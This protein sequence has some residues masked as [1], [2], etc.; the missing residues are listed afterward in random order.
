MTGAPGTSR[1]APA[2]SWRGAPADA[3]LAVRFPNGSEFECAGGA[4]RGIG[5]VRAGGVA[6]R[7]AEEC[8]WPEIATPDGLAVDRFEY[9]S[10]AVEGRAVVI[11]AGPV[12]PR[13]LVR[14]SAIRGE[15]R[16]RP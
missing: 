15:H 6:L 10:A 8:I 1:P 14:A 3:A 11:C 16:T 7:G 5:A 12:H 4:C 13:N 2:L 9:V